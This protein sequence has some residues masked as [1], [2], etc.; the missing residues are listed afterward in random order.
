MTIGNNL[1]PALQRK[2]VD[3]LDLVLTLAMYPFYQQN[4]AVKKMRATE[5]QA[6][7]TTTKDICGA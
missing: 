4:S 7:V 5:I 1:P 2:K 6:K 3:F